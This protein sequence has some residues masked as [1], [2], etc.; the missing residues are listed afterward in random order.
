M[1][2]VEELFAA[3]VVTASDGSTEGACTWVA[4]EIGF[5]EEDEMNTLLASGVGGFSEGSEG[6][7]RGGEG[8]GLSDGEFEDLGH[9]CL[10]V[11]VVGRTAGKASWKIDI[12][13][14]FLHVLDTTVR[15]WNAGCR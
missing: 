9:D 5:R 8:A 15:P 1:E 10:L 7:G 3:A 12:I 4:A 2:V 6:G 11:E 13:E 14:I